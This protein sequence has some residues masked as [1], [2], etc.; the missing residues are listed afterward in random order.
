MDTN[1]IEINYNEIISNKLFI[2]I[3]LRKSMNHNKGI[4]Y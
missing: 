3:P 1:I 4:R 2:I